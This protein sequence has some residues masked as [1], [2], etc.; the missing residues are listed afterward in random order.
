MNE[1]N[2]S[3]TSLVFWPYHSWIDTQIEIY[4][5]RANQLPFNTAFLSIKKKLNENQV[6]PIPGVLQNIIFNDNLS[7]SL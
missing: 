4:V 3:L 6:V 7:E 1:D 5:R 2:F